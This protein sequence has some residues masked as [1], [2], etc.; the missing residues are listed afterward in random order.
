[1]IGQPAPK[2]APEPDMDEARIREIIAGHTPLTAD[3]FPG[4]RPASVL[5]P[6]HPAPEGLSIIFTKRPDNLEQHPGQ[7]SFPGGTRDPEDLDP[8]ATALRETHEEIGVSPASVEVWGRLHQEITVTRFSVAPFVG[9]VPH[10]YE[11]ILSPREVERL[12]IVPLAHL[13]DP[14]NSTEGSYLWG[15]R[16]YRTYQYKYGEDIIWGATARM[17]HNLLC[18]L[19]TGDEQQ[20][21][22]FSL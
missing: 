21:L 19:T 16:N 13:L 10:P 15:G 12:I 22:P 20:E 7:I 5:I 17:I 8:L 3:P 14:G 1:M 18:L 11:F 4:L 9:L 6:F 2:T